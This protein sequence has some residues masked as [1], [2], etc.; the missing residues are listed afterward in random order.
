MDV[1]DDDLFAVFDD[2]STKDKKVVLPEDDEAK[3]DKVDPS[4]L[5]KEIC[6]PRSKRPADKEDGEVDS[7]KLKTD[8]DTTLMTGLSDAEVKQKIEDDEKHIRGD[9]DMEKVKIYIFVPS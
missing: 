6:G 7:K 9:E 1:G 2:D 4:S 8:V 3:P 5:V